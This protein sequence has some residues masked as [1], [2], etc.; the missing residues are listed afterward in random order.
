MKI[1]SV[2]L[3]KYIRRLLR[4]KLSGKDKKLFNSFTTIRKRK[5]RKIIRKYLKKWIFD[6]IS[7]TNSKSKRLNCLQEQIVKVAKTLIQKQKIAKQEA[8]QSN[9]KNSMYELETVK[10][11]KLKKWNSTEV[12]YQF[13]INDKAF[14]ASGSIDEFQKMIYDALD[15]IWQKLK[16]KVKPTDKVRM[17][18]DSSSLIKKFSTFL[19]PASDF[20]IDLLMN[21]IVNALQSNETIATD[22]NIEITFQHIQIP[23]AGYRPTE[24]HIGYPVA[25]SK[26]NSIVQ[27]HATDN[28][29]MP[30]AIYLG[31]RRL[32]NG[33][34][35]SHYKNLK[36]IRRKDQLTKKAK[37]FYR[38]I[39]GKEH[40][41]QM[42]TVEDL[43]L[44]QQSLNNVQIIAYSWNAGK[45]L[46][47]RGADHEKKLFLVHHENHVDLITQINGFFGKDY[48]CNIC[49]KG[50]NSMESHTCVK[51][52]KS[53][54]QSTCSA[55]DLDATIKCDN[56]NRFFKNL[57]CFA[58]HRKIPKKGR[59]LCEKLK[60]CKDCGRRY[61]VNSKK[62]TSHLCDSIY[63]SNCKME[64]P[65]DHLC[66]IKPLRA[67]KESDFSDN[68]IGNL[69]EKN[70]D[71]LI[72]LSST[73]DDIK[74]SNTDIADFNSRSFVYY[75]FEAY[76]SL[77]CGLKHIPNLIVAQTN[78]EP[79]EEFKWFGDDCVS[80]FCKWAINPTRKNT[81]FV[82]HNSKRYDSYFILEWL[83]KN[84][85]IEPKVMINGGSLFE[86]KI[87]QLKIRFIDSLNFLGTALANLPAMF[88]KSGMFEKGFFPFKFNQKENYQYVGKMPEPEFFDVKWMSAKRQNDFWSWYNTEKDKSWCFMDE[89]LL[90]CRDDVKILRVCCEDF[91]K[92]F[93]DLSTVDPFESVT[94]AAACNRVF[95][96]NF[97]IPNTIAIIPPNGYIGRDRQSHVA[98]QWLEY[99]AR[100]LKTT[101]RHAGNGHEFRIR[102]RKIKLDGV[103]ILS[104][105]TYSMNAYEFLGCYYHGCKLCYSQTQM[106]TLMGRPMFEVYNSTQARLK[107]LKNAGWNVTTIWE[108]QFKEL[109]KTNLEA[110]K[111][112]DSLHLEDPLN[113]RDAFFGGRT[114]AAVLY[115]KVKDNER[116]CY[117]DINSLYPYVNKECFYPLGHPIILVG[118]A[119]SMDN[120]RSYFGMIKCKVLAP[121]SLLHPVLP[122]RYREKLMF[123]LC[124]S[125]AQDP[126][127]NKIC[128]HSDSDRAIEGTW[129]TVELFKALDVGY[130]LLSVSEIWHFDKS[131]NNLF[132]GYINTFLAVKQHSRGLPKKWH[133]FDDEKILNEVKEYMSEFENHEGVKLELCKM[134]KEKNDGMYQC[135]KICLNCFWGKFGQRLNKTQ[136]QFCRK[137][138]DFWKLLSDQR[139]NIRSVDFIND[140]LAQIEFTEQ[141]EFL[142]P[143]LNT[144][145]II[146]AF[147][148]CYARLK[149]YEA[150]YNL[151]NRV[152]YY[153]TDSV[154]YVH[155]DG[156]YEPEMGDFLGQYK[157][158]IGDGDYIQ[159]FCSGG[160]KNYS[161]K[162]M[163][164]KKELKV[165]GFSL[166]PSTE[167]FLNF[168][169]VS[170]MVKSKD[171]SSKINLK[172]GSSMK[173]DKM[174]WSIKTTTNR[175]DYRLIY[176]KRL[177]LNNSYSTI[178]FGFC[179]EK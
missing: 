45:S 13:K 179:F 163:K 107:F 119:I 69:E 106:N 148:T 121:K 27:V 82:A 73:T 56:C 24:L 12:S 141:D 139:L 60:T 87:S 131:S 171:F 34:Q 16:P 97:L 156:L 29:C 144:N 130:K 101:I 71:P 133:D 7:E 58:N 35:D 142:L 65:S 28:T 127:R 115:Y 178:P 140:D 21:C 83:I 72:Y 67:S 110:K 162:T 80:Q 143:G 165:R 109:L 118:E 52:C 57:E 113:P 25:R 103:E 125:C 64:V 75:D 70:I 164:G 61:K 172:M 11:R 108:C 99:E 5:I 1:D 168:E 50:H 173:R 157:D 92:I 146:A 14:K 169:S 159:E 122:K 132:K 47:F 49:L 93:F 38:E 31:L 42:C 104:D 145:I 91:R 6:S 46:M 74:A 17:V 147:T 176:D 30:A 154:I 95:R 161:Y 174:T 79:M 33:A 102:G 66:Y 26:L 149:L 15:S 124:N 18:L 23:V 120:L 126:P 167:Q 86:I 155:K 51:K 62:E 68:E 88:G 78:S 89:I 111:F 59:S 128:T 3:R 44:F 175:K 100:R 160:P 138:A 76:E 54:L 134:C 4:R 116:I 10:E 39:I 22:D 36:N 105:G 55:I 41:G 135:A 53:C 84:S 153:D 81:T 20:S 158:E 63:C 90:Y 85:S 137:E 129:V 170:E 9:E 32:H 2:R 151:N 40:N 152:L 177:I 94:I 43:A 8:S 150:L 19:V 112:V 48:Y 114:N 117:A 37:Q 98:K 123:V 77:E 136:M 96:K 166:K